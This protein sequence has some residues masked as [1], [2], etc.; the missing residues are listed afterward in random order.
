MDNI[1]KIKFLTKQLITYSESY[2][3]LDSPLITDQEYDRLYDELKRLED[4][5]NFWL[6]NSPTRKVQG[7]VLDK[8]NKVVHSKPM[9]SAN[10]TKDIGEIKT[11][12]NN[13][14][15][16]CSYKLDGLTL[17]VKYKNGNLVNAITRGNGIQGEDVT[18]QAKMIYNLPLRIPH[19]EELELR[20]ECVI[21]WSSFKEINSTLEQPFSHPRNMAA[22]SLRS[23]D[24]NIARERKLAYIPFECVT[25]INDS[26]LKE[27]EY[28]DNLGFNT[29]GRYTGSVE[30]CVSNMKAEDSEFP[31]DGLIFEIDSKRES[32]N[33]GATSH[34]ENCRIALKWEDIIYKTILR[35][36]VWKTNK[37]GT[38]SPVAI[39][40]EVDL[41]GALTTKATL[42][43][44]QYIKKLQL[45]IGDEIGV[46][47]ANMV[48]PK[49]VENYTRSDTLKLPEFCPQCG[50]ALKTVCS[51]NSEFLQCTNNSCM[52]KSLALFEHFI[53]KNAMNIE[54]MSSATLNFLIDNKF[55]EDF[56]DLYKMTDEDYVIWSSFSGF[57][58]ISVGKLKEAI[59]RSRNVKLANFINSLSIPNIGFAGA[60]T[61]ANYCDNDVNNFID[62]CLDQNFNWSD[63]ED[64]GEITATSIK[65]FIKT[66]IIESSRILKLI[67]QLNFEKAELITVSNKLNGSTFC[68]TGKLEKFSN[69]DQ[70]VANIEQNGG[71][72]VSGVNTKCN[73]LINNDINSS[74]SK[75]KRAKQLNI[76]IITEDEY[77]KLVQ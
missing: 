70:L 16:Y 5:S 21:S 73:Y 71:K 59:E 10:K 13:K 58:E 27:L 4:Q 76:P 17:V 65:A 39:F 51:D 36:V 75:N 14:N 8:F 57:G 38:T 23:L 41:D 28:L 74:S 66:N 34:H 56:V 72:F 61:I 3:N 67:E 64:F 30:D 69:R 29:V 48:I 6:S 31:V 32:S 45:G 40:D 24:T 11:A 63:L 62:I 60:K 53:S 19:K 12:V 47:R 54:G 1:A 18:E 15:F 44:A 68:I 35:D 37:T 42:H 33:L 9:L 7:Q 46:I 55:I 50:A 49:V 25:H 20:G 52:S 2:Y 26:K 77:L 22:G 43:N